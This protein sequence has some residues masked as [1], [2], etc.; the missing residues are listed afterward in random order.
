[1]DKKE[2]SKMV[3]FKYAEVFP[4]WDEVVRLDRPQVV[5]RAGLSTTLIF[6]TAYRKTTLIRIPSY[7]SY[8]VT[9]GFQ[10]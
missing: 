10:P 6:D 2:V 9:A 4:D 8:S 5:N 7:V 3:T 1:M